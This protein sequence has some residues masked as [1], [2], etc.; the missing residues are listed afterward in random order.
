MQLFTETDFEQRCGMFTNVAT[1]RL[2]SSRLQ[3]ADFKFFSS[4]FLWIKSIK[5]YNHKCNTF[6]LTYLTNRVGEIKSNPLKKYEFS[7]ER[8]L[9][10]AAYTICK[11]CN[12]PT[13]FK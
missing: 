9:P 4:M 6:L 2:F 3:T 8:M 11:S 1:T 12:Y 7:R 13:V 10:N 5:V